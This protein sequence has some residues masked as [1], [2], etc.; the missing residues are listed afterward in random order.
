[1]PEFAS[2]PGG[3]CAQEPSS[4]E[5][6]PPQMTCPRIEGPRSKVHELVAY[7]P[8]SGVLGR[9]RGRPVDNGSA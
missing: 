6:H 7:E 5:P 9:S 3:T 1:M 8:W 4:E 2:G